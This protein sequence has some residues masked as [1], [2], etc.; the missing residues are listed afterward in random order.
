M[1]N[2]SLEHSNT[3]E[4]KSLSGEGASAVEDFLQRLDIESIPYVSWKN[5]HQLS[6]AISGELD[7]DIFVPIGFRAAVMRTASKQAWVRLENP[8]AYFPWVTHLFTLD[9]NQKS[10]H[11]HVYFKVVTGES[12]IKEYILPLDDLLIGNRV[13]SADGRLWILN[14]RAQ[15]YIF[16]IR[17]LL[18]AGSISSR[19]LYLREIE[20][21]QIEWNGCHQS[22]NALIN[23]GPVLLN[24]YIHSSGLDGMSFDLPPVGVAMRFRFSLSPFLRYPW[25]S[26]PAFRLVSFFSRLQ[27]KLFLKRKKIFPNG[28]LVLAISG[29]DGSGKTSMLNEVDRVLA[30]FLTVRRFSLGRPQGSVLEAIRRL[31]RRVDSPRA[32]GNSENGVDY[33]KK[34]LSTKAAISAAALSLL[35]LRMA[36]NAVK[37]AANGQLAL[38]DRWPTDVLGMM[39]GPSIGVGVSRSFIWQLCARIEFWAYQRMPRADVCIFLDAPAHR[40]I[41]R[42]RRRV[43]ADKE[44]DQEIMDRYSMNSRSVPLARKVIRFDNDGPFDQK[45]KE[46]LSLIWS[47]IAN[48]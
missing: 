30:S 9:E 20:S 7:L 16:A 18:K 34:S 48:N 5:N 11:I 17:H 31:I 36:K 27:N 13:R 6:S 43:K 12:W 40:L 23:W 44:S 24:D 1:S 41:A 42:N 45:G 14:E 33:V 26:L 4:D 38:V 8:V 39:D 35:R 10:F 2:E 25:W 29:V 22:E 47:E 28:G 19:W 46:L 21:Y 3:R 32:Y 15:A 37:S